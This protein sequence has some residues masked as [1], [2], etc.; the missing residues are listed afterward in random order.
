[1]IIPEG[2]TRDVSVSWP[3][4]G[5][6]NPMAMGMLSLR[7]GKSPTV[8]ADHELS[9]RTRYL[10]NAETAT[11]PAQDPP[12]RLQLP[13]LTWLQLALW[14]VSKLPG[15]QGACFKLIMRTLTENQIQA[16]AR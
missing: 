7:C 9:C 13:G 15:L 14:L 16:V 4:A 8:T 11:Q 5:R 1:M 6:D 3:P 10:K 2:H 12:E